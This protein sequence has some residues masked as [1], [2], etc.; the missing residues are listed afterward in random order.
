MKRLLAALL[1]FASPAWAIAPGLGGAHVGLTISGTTKFQTMGATSCGGPCTMEVFVGP[2]G[3]G[4][5]TCGTPATLDASNNY[6]NVDTCTGMTAGQTYDYRVDLHDGA[7]TVTGT[8]A[9]LMAGTF[10]VPEAAPDEFWFW[11][12]GCIGLGLSTYP[13]SLRNQTAL[14]ELVIDKFRVN[15]VQANPGKYYFGALL[16]DQIYH[17]QWDPNNEIEVGSS[18]LQDQYA[19]ADYRACYLNLFNRAHINGTYPDSLQKLLNWSP[20]VAM[21]DDH[22]FGGQGGD[23]HRGCV[24]NTPAGDGGSYL[25]G[26][27]AAIESFLGVNPVVPTGT[28]CI[29][30]SADVAYFTWTIGN[31]QFWMLDTRSFSSPK[32]TD[33]TLLGVGEVLNGDPDEAQ[34]W[35]GTDPNQLSWL[36]STLAASTAPIKVI[37]TSF[38]FST[39][40]FTHAG[41]AISGDN[42]M[43]WPTERATVLG[44]LQAAAETSTVL[45]LTSDFHYNMVYQIDSTGLVEAISARIAQSL[46][47]FSD[48]PTNVYWKEVGTYGGT[49]WPSGTTQ[50]TAIGVVHV[51]GNNVTV[52]WYGA[53]GTWGPSVRVGPPNYKLGPSWRPG[54]W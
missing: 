18:G 37:F 12:S 6:G 50:Q 23:W 15:E 13:T 9:N 5:T 16:G 22:E 49:P 38:A 26:R 54:F 44:Y 46:Q 3:G 34:G 53:D 33:G 28:D 2:T 35:T 41:G 48:E 27:A 4:L 43:A 7:A 30:D 19:L 8:A 32:N 42:W 11:Y 52:T 45:V 1:L 29:A 10:K 39:D 17:D 51:K 14:N 24:E 36:Q 21:W 47:A 31:V 20:L 40:G 25:N